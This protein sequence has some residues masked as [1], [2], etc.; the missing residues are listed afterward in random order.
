MTTATRRKSQP[1]VLT[2]T[3]GPEAFAALRCMLLLLRDMV[4]TK[5]AN[6]TE[7]ENQRL[8]QGMVAFVQRNATPD[9]RMAI[10]QGAESLPKTPWQMDVSIMVLLLG[11]K[12]GAE[13]LQ[14]IGAESKQPEPDNLALW[15]K[16][17]DWLLDD[18]RAAEGTITMLELERARERGKAMAS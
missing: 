1:K 18:L 14:V 11:M 2:Y 5:V 6:G 8:R 9:F 13:Y 12:A 10:Q 17:R 7:E 15:K 16:R 3:D 4:T